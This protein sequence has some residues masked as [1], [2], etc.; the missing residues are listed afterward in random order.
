MIEEEKQERRVATAKMLFMIAE[1]LVDGTFTEFT[2][3]VK[4]M[5]RTTYSVYTD[6]V[7]HGATKLAIS[8]T[9]NVDEA[10]FR[11][12][13]RKRST[14]MEAA[15]ANSTDDLVH[16][17]FDEEGNVIT[18][19]PQPKVLENPEV[20]KRGDHKFMSDKVHPN[21]CHICLLPRE[22]HDS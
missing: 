14:E 4:Q 18:G 8:F 3:T 19:S 16:L 1:G 13:I 6:R 15:L 21:V 17:T 12:D 22:N 11:E 2:F 9:M 10:K 20:P 7:K 5:Q